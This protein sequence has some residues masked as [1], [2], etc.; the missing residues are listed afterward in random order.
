MRTHISLFVMTLGT[1]LVLS[2]CNSAKGNNNNTA[3]KE[4]LINTAELDSA[5]HPG[6]DF[7]DYA[8]RRWIE[9]NP[10][11]ETESRWGVF[12]ILADESNEVVKLIF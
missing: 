5:I 12:N 3:K 10:I 7:Y 6:D 8:N 1:G 11:P 4:P 9:K 2:G